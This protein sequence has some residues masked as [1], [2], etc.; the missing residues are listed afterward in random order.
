MKN[1]RK[2][3]TSERRRKKNQKLKTPTYT[4][5]RYAAKAADISN[6]VILGSINS[7]FKCETVEEAKRTFRK[8]II[9]RMD[10]VRKYLNYYVR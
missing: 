3:Y 1:L 7:M 8:N 4:S 9:K 10:N 6:K 5:R 2:K